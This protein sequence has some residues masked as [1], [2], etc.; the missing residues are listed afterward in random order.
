M[1]CN[2]AAF[3]QW[4]NCFASLILLRQFPAFQH[5]ET[6]FVII[7]SF[8]LV[9]LLVFVCSF[10]LHLNIRRIYA[11][12]VLLFS[13]ISTLA[14]FE[15]WFKMFC[16][17]SQHFNIEQRFLIIWYFG[18]ALQHWANVYDYLPFY[19]LVVAFSHWAC[20]MIFCYLSK[21]TFTNK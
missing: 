8:F 6:F 20:F 11:H 5:W 3:Q 16:Y 21:L 1:F 19:N 4:P 14:Y 15:C 10:L 18:C 12:L 7:C 17:I 13:Y 9:W 2:F